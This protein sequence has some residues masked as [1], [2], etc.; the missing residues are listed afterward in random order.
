MKF[1]YSLI[2]V[3]LIVTPLFFSETAWAQ[4]QWERIQS[5]FDRPLE[6]ISGKENGQA[7]WLLSDRNAYRM[8]A[9]EKIWNR[10]FSLGKQ[11]RLNAIVPE[12]PNRLFILTNEGVFESNDSARTWQKTFSAL[13]DRSTNSLCIS[14][15]PR[16]P[17]ILYLGTQRGLYFSL[18]GGQSWSKQNALAYEEIRKVLLH[19]LHDNKI[20]AAT[21]TDFYVSD[22]YGKSFRETFH[23]QRGSLEEP[24]PDDSGTVTDESESDISL[25]PS[26]FTVKISPFDS[27]ELFLGTSEGIFSS[28][29]MGKTWHPVTKNGLGN[30]GIQDFEISSRDGALFTATSSGIYQLTPGNGRWVEIHSGMTSSAAK[31]LTLSRGGA[32]TL[33]AVVGNDVFRWQREL[34]PYPEIRGPQPFADLSRAGEL[35]NLLA[36]EPSALEVQRAAIRYADVGN[37]KIKRWHFGSRLRALVPG[38][39]LGK[40]FSVRNNIDID[41]AGTNQPDEFIAGPDNTTKGRDISLDWDLGDLIWGSSQTSIDSREKLMVELRN[42]VVNEVTRLYYERR[43]LV[44][45]LYL[46]RPAAEQEFFDLLLRIDELTSY[47]DGL[48]G[49]YFSKEL[50]KRDINYG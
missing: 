35:K 19:P 36:R 48:T 42:D 26:I 6:K 7:L 46:S 2:H 45:S 40:D 38:L 49:G 44:M 1:R 34:P 23:L 5:P 29:D 47:I 32:E 37:G 20:F 16:D 11:S 27:G 24:Y 33:Y 25:S 21:D 39:S 17:E 28:W 9:G 50:L 15:H 13:E 10:I 14:S 41:R 3:L 8:N 31:S 30:A 43:R 18:D 12:K 22:D 4:E